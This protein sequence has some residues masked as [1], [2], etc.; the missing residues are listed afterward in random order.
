MREGSSEYNT[1]FVRHT[2]NIT[3]DRVLAPRRLKPTPF[4]R[5][6]RTKKRRYLGTMDDPSAERKD[7]DHQS[8]SKTDQRNGP[9]I[10]S[11]VIF[12]CYLGYA[13]C[14][15]FCSRIRRCSR[16]FSANTLTICRRPSEVISCSRDLFIPEDRQRSR[17]P[18]LLDKWIIISEL[19]P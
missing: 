5:I 4:V 18:Y 2:A 8:R 9:L 16:N 17:A 6:C 19:G 3:R 12:L 1:A 7:H 15:S 11:N 14:P 13:T 10:S